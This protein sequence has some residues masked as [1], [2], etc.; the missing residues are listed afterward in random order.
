MGVVATN[1]VEFGSLNLKSLKI[2]ENDEE[3]VEELFE[4][5]LEG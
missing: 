3:I 4:P 1:F 2:S 5:K